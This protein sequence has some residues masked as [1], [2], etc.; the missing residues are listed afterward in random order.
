MNVSS[1]A[2]VEEQDIIAPL[3]KKI[4]T[5][6]DFIKRSKKRQ[7]LVMSHRELMPHSVRASVGVTP[8]A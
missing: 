7:P 2:E 1:K 8:T 3:K 6:F 5:E 4:L